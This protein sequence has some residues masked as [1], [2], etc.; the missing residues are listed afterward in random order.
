M[1]PIEDEQSKPVEQDEGFSTASHILH[2]IA[3]ESVEELRAKQPLSLMDAVATLLKT[4]SSEEVNFKKKTCEACVKSKV[5]CSGAM[6]CERCSSRAMQCVYQMEKKRGRR[7]GSVVTKRDDTTDATTALRMAEKKNR[8]IDSRQPLALTRLAM[9]GTANMMKVAHAGLSPSHS[10]FSKTPSLQPSMDSSSFI[11][12]Q[13]ASSPMPSGAS[14]SLPQNAGSGFGPGPNMSMANYSALW[15]PA[16][17]QHHQQQQSRGGGGH[18]PQFVYSQHPMMKPPSGS[19]NDS[20]AMNAPSNVSIAHL[21]GGGGPNAE[22]GNL[23]TPW[24]ATSSLLPIISPKNVTSGRNFFVNPQGAAGP[25]AAPSSS[26]TNPL[27]SISSLSSPPPNTV[28]TAATR[29]MK[30]LVALY[31][32]ISAVYNWSLTMLAFPANAM[33]DL[34]MQ[35]VQSQ[36]WFEMQF[37]KILMRVSGD[38]AERV[39]VAAWIMENGFRVYADPSTFNNV[40]MVGY[41]GPKTLAGLPPPE[42]QQLYL[43]ISSG[44][45]YSHSFLGRLRMSCISGDIKVDADEGFANAFGYSTQEII[46][47]MLWAKDGLMPWCADALAVVA[48]DDSDVIDYCKQVSQWSS[49]KTGTSHVEK[50]LH[51]VSKFGQIQDCIL[52]AEICERSHATSG[53]V[54]VDVV[55]D[56]YSYIV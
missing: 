38:A 26:S 44:R 37:N 11:S 50:R 48:V 8:V 4:S 14:R 1:P 35:K 43:N 12:F 30:M 31:R 5:R 42:Q 54:K 28:V 18:S 55:F 10:G 52:V 21:M 45:D 27:V 49:I 46:N 36:Q 47:V 53:I 29:W 16:H 17:H 9:T 3:G 40:S 41:V 32:E 7:P 24:L 19:L 2:K 15:H 13:Q 20:R 6:P 25:A 23:D 34:M 39:N 51:V 22:D 33:G 56:F